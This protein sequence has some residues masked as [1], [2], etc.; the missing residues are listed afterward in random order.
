MPRPLPRR[1]F[2]ATA[3]A[4]L[5]PFGCERAADRSQTQVALWFSYGGRNRE[6]LEGLVR[7][8][9][10]VQAQ[11]RV[12]AVFQGD[13]FE[14]L[15][16][17]R[18][19]L[20]AGTPPSLTHVVS[21]VVPYLE[22]A[23]VLEPLAPYEGAST[24]DVLPAFRQEQAFR[25]APPGLC[26]LPFNRSTPIAYLNRSLFDRAQLEPPRTWAE[27]RDVA[28]AFTRR[29]GESRHGFGCPIDWWFWVALVEQAGGSV[30]E[31]DGRISLGDEAGVAALEFWQGLARERL[32]KVPTGRDYNAWEQINQD[33]LAGRVAMIWSTTAFV[34]YLE[35]N[36]RFPVRAAPLPA[37]VRRA[38]P[39]GGT[40]WVIPKAASAPEK[41]AAWRFL[42]FMLEP[43]QVVDWATSTGYIPVTQAAVN[44][45]S[46]RGY[47]RVHPNDAV[48]LEQLT[49][50]S[51]WPWSIRLFRVAREIVQPRLERVVFA[52]ADARR[53]LAEARALCATEFA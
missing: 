2:L 45:L 31:P 11:D 52:G 41:A 3:A 47:Y 40:H 24:L 53:E 33:F 18:I 6:V 5:G 46:E 20:A 19:A 29:G 1:E 4:A 8:Y 14:G 23:G 35:D 10:A 51:P 26:A 44:A 22:N 37:G 36:A 39:T 9:N 17:L 34:R 50:A 32:M 12:Q 13:Y 7:R 43:P 49:V 16:K 42:R 15:A 27:V 21:E 28:R 25:G 48:A 30:V 38:V